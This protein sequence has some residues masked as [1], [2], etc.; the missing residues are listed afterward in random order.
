MIELERFRACMSIQRQSLHI[1]LPVGLGLALDLAAKGQLALNLAPSCSLVAHE[2]RGL[3]LNLAPSHFLGAPRTHS[4]Y[5]L[6][7]S[8]RLSLTAQHLVA[9]CPLVAGTHRLRWQ[10][11]P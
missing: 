8:R 2:S 4:P 7:T 1:L 11:L 10:P 5:C 3:A 9:P 6:V